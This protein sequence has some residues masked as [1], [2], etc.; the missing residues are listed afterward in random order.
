MGLSR[1]NAVA[2]MPST[3]RQVLGH[4]LWHVRH[5]RAV[6]LPMDKMCRV[7]AADDI[8]FINPR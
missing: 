4:V 7:R 8:D 1:A 3:A 2:Y 6:A 5:E